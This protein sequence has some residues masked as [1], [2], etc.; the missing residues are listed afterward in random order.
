[1][2]IVVGPDYY[3]YIMDS[4][5]EK[6]ITEINGIPIEQ[7]VSATYYNPP[8]PDLVDSAGLPTQFG[9]ATTQLIQSISAADGAFYTA[10]YDSTDN[11]GILGEFNRI[12]GTK[13]AKATLPFD[14]E[15]AQIIGFLTD[16]EGGLIIRDAKTNN[17][18]IQKS[19][20]PMSSSPQFFALGA[21]AAD[22]TALKLIQGYNAGAAIDTAIFENMPVEAVPLTSPTGDM[23][24]DS[25]IRYMKTKLES[26][27][28]GDSDKDE[29]VDKIAN[30]IVASMLLA[31]P[32]HW[33]FLGDY[34]SAVSGLFEAFPEVKKRVQIVT[35]PTLTW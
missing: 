21:T 11:A 31:E 9:Q 30:Y 18:Y 12:A 3:S 20:A 10:D 27:S 29:Y 4:L 34:F 7:F 6:N 28:A 8:S 2:G 5:K 17:L 26:F 14:E 23:T 33:P 16:K 24:N 19:Y 22:D 15:D 13:L 35:A 32:H 25:D 1:M